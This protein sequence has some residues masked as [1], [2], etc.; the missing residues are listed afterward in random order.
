L[1]V[2]GSVTVGGAIASGTNNRLLYQ[3]GSGNLAESN[4]AQYD[5]TTATFTDL[6]APTTNLTDDTNKRFVTD[7]QLVVI[8]NTSNTNTGDQTSIVGISGTKAQFDTA[9]S[10]G[11][12]LYVGDA[13]TAHA[14]SHKLGGGDVILL[15]EF[16]N[17]TGSIEFNQQQGLQFRLENRTSDPVSSAV[18]EIWLRT[19]L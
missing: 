18:G 5:G 14:A 13:P 2:A 11:N 9:V 10:D 12:I 6:A 17:P 4:G 8:G 1:V 3:D 7:A 19:D 16:G 15:N